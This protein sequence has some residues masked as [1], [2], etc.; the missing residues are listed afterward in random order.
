M[1][2]HPF[3]I[4]AILI[5]LLGSNLTWS[6]SLRSHSEVPCF[7]WDPNCDHVWTI[8]TRAMTPATSKVTTPMTPATSKV[9][10]TTTT[11]TTSPTTSAMEMKSTTTPK[12]TSSKATTLTMSTSSSSHE[13]HPFRTSLKPT[14]RP[15]ISSTKAKE[16]MTTSIAST[17]SLSLTTEDMNKHLSTTENPTTMFLSKSTL[18]PTGPSTHHASVQPTDSD[19]ITTELPRNRTSTTESNFQIQTSNPTAAF[20]PSTKKSKIKLKKGMFP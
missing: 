8:S 13:T 14:N 1:N 11:T 19:I 2:F 9:T 18:H 5:C 3:L 7:P 20:I 10:T 17:D 15:L 6:I 16:N 12:A 4:S